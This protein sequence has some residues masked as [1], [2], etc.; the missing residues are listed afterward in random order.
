MT[1]RLQAE[2]IHIL[3]EA[4]LPGGACD[5]ILNPE[6]GFVIRGGREMENYYECLWDLYRSIP[7]LEVENASRSG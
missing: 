4:A 1:D 7:S 6:L 5:G 3:E 2:R